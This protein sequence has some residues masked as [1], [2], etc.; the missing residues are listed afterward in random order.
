[1]LG[2]TLPC[3]AQHVAS[4]TSHVVVTVAVNITV[5]VCLISLTFV[6]VAVNITVIVCLISLTFVTVCVA[7]T[8]SASKVL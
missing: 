8:P 2:L 3:L 5:I 7:V 4:P 1:M 6:T